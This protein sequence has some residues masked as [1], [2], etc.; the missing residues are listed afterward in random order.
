M[1][2]SKILA[3]LHVHAAASS[4]IMR[5][6]YGLARSKAWSQA[7]GLLQMISIPNALL[8][9]PFLG[10]NNAITLW[11][12]GTVIL[13]AGWALFRYEFQI[14]SPRDGSPFPLPLSAVSLRMVDLVAVQQP[15]Q[16][17]EDLLTNVLG[18]AMS[19]ACDLENGTGGPHTTENLFAAAKVVGDTH[20]KRDDV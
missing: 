14:I 10:F 1:S 18:L 11:T 2:H 7:L 3:S 16:K 9:F 8:G 17:E 20:E 13:A 5:H 19:A 15:L 12:F 4:R 6:N